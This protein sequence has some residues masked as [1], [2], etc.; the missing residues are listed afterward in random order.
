[1]EEAD[2][3]MEGAERGAVYLCSAAAKDIRSKAGGSQERP[4]PP[5]NLEQ[6]FS[7][8]RG[9]TIPVLPMVRP[10]EGTPDR[11]PA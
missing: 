4:L 3:E 7:W 5:E 6:E 9:S 8:R 11:T 10:G 2:G 1:V